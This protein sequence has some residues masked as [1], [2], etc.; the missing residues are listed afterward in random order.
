MSKTYPRR[1]TKQNSA[2]RDD[3]V[4][5]VELGRWRRKGGKAFEAPRVQVDVVLDVHEARHPVCRIFQCHSPHKTMNLVALFQKQLGKIATILPGNPRNEYAF[6]VKSEVAG[7]FCVGRSLRDRQRV[8]ER[9]AYVHS[10]TACPRIKRNDR[11]AISGYH[12]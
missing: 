2:R 7:T 9:L 4:H 8:S 6:H 1:S 11:G 10:F 12:A 3:R 5:P